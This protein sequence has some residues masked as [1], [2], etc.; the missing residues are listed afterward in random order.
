MPIHLTNQPPYG[1]HFSGRQRGHGADTTSS[2]AAELRPL[3]DAG[4]TSGIVSGVGVSRDS[5]MERGS[6]AAD[7]SDEEAMAG[8]TNKLTKLW[9]VRASHILLPVANRV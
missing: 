3:G 4:L 8:R 7:D 1:G 2:A 9:E 5:S 6:A